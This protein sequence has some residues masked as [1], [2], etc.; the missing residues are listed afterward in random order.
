M[1]KRYAASLELIA[2]LVSC[3][4]P[5]I[6]ATLLKIVTFKSEVTLREK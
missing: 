3:D 2:L 6:D 4:I 5:Y 1:C